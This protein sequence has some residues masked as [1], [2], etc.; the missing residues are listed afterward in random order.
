MIPTTKS[1]RKQ[2]S[3][4]KSK[5][6]RGPKKYKVEWPDVVV[7]DYFSETD[8][9]RFKNGFTGAQISVRVVENIGDQVVERYVPMT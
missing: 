7:V 2:K 5:F 4:Y 8:F 6:A 1:I 9:K 3:R